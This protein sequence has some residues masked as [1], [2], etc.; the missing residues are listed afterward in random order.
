MIVPLPPRAASFSRPTRRI[1]GTTTASV[2][3]ATRAV[4][5]KRVHPLARDGRSARWCRL[6]PLQPPE[7]AVEFA[8]RSATA[9]SAANLRCV[10]CWFGLGVGVARCLSSL[11]RAF[12]GGRRNPAAPRPSHSTRSRLRDRRNTAM[13]RR[14]AR[15]SALKPANSASSGSPLRQPVDV[16]CVVPRARAA[17]AAFGPPSRRRGFV[18]LRARFSR[19]LVTR[20]RAALRSSL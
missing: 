18:A 16:A 1:F 5:T 4:F 10:N 19:A 14:L 20:G 13:P 9:Q 15:R 12:G 8:A 3:Q 11:R 17:C 2:S 6:S 7:P